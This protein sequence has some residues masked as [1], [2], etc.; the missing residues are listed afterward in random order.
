MLTFVDMTRLSVNVNKLATLRNARG[1]NSP[2]VLE[3]TKEI[4]QWGAHSITVHPRPD[5]RHIRK[6]DVFEISAQLKNLPSPIE[7][8]IEGYPS[9]DF[10]N[11]ITEVGP[12]QCT[13]VPDA[14]NA[15]TS[16]AGWP[17]AENKARLK[18]ISQRLKERGICGSLFVDP[19]SWS[20]NETLAL[21]DIAPSRVELYTEN[22]AVH[23]DTPKLQE[24]LAPYQ[25]LA[26]IAKNLHIGVNAGHDLNQQ[27]L[28]TLVQAIP[29]I[30]EV[31]IGHAL[32]CEALYDGMEPTIKNYLKILGWK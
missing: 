13:L 30:D 19:H 14:P 7:L 8:N 26:H 27:N 32:I 11:L 1:K 12:T 2:N 4:A 28:G 3:M 24:T 10:L 31:S 25:S 22:F 15:L 9:E 29:F 21:E 18:E 16:N 20:H 5:G 6:S 23:F 17:L